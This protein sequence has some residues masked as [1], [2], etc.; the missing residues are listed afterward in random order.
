MRPRDLADLL[1]L[2]MLWGGSYIFMRAAAPAF[3]PVALIAWRVGIGALVLIPLLARAG[4]LPALRSQAGGLLVV[5][6]TNSALPFLLFAYATLTITGGFAALL[7][8]TAPLWAAVVAYVGWGERLRRTQVIGLLLGFAGVVLLVWDRLAPA[9]DQDGPANAMAI[10][11][12][13]AATLSYGWS[14]NYSR[15]RF[16]GV[17]PLLVAGGSQVA[18]ALS[19]LPLGVLMPPS[20]PP[21]PTAWLCALVLGVACTGLAYPLFFRLIEN[22]GAARAISVT[23]L[24]PV[25]AALWGGLF[26]SETLGVRMLIG[27]A[28]V[29]LGTALA[30]GVIGAPSAGAGPRSADLRAD[31]RA[32][33]ADAQP[34]RAYRSISC[35][36]TSTISPTA[37]APIHHCVRRCSWMSRSIRRAVASSREARRAAPARHAAA[38]AAGQ[39]RRPLRRLDLE[40]IPQA[41]GNRPA[42]PSSARGSAWP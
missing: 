1:L 34:P 18:A 12:A 33:L 15:R 14:A 5:G 11:A 30:A 25:F 37:N 9:A 31:L 10:A 13:L 21:S 23:F 8:A 3:G 17:P 42:V 29:L 27:G 4:H 16:A 36:S 26:L 39:H 40:V 20:A 6:L 41:G 2:A 7:G 22:A 38:A 28:I 32:D 35:S 24:V 19:M